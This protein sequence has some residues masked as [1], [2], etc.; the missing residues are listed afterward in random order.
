MNSKLILALVA[1]LAIIGADAD[2]PALSS[3]SSKIE[4]ISASAS[5]P[6]RTP[7]I[8]SAASAFSRISSELS[9]SLA[10]RQSSIASGSASASSVSASATSVASSAAS[11]MSSLTSSASQVAQTQAPSAANSIGGYNTLILQACALAALFVAS[12]V[13]MLA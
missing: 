12:F 11:V 7:L 6:N 10:T 8:S 5:G 9:A 4:S 2:V 13:A 3:L 1:V